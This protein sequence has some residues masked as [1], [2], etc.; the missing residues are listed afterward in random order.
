M[1]RKAQRFLSLRAPCGPRNVVWGRPQQVERKVTTSRRTRALRRRWYRRWRSSPLGIFVRGQ[2]NA[3]LAGLT[4]LLIFQVVSWGVRALYGSSEAP[5]GGARAFLF[6]AIE[7]IK[8][9]SAVSGFAVYSG[10]EVLG[11]LQAVRSSPRVGQAETGAAEHAG[12]GA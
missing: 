1:R 7:W 12:E 2:V 6:A 5:E 10:S 8:V 11:L 3:A 9:L 4:A